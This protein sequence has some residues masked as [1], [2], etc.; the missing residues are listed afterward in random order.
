MSTDELLT[1]HSRLNNAGTSVTSN[2]GP[3]PKPGLTIYESGAGT[4]DLR[5]EVLSRQLF[6]DRVAEAWEEEH[7]T[8]VPDS[9]MVRLLER[10]ELKPG[11]V[12]LD[13]GCGTGRLVPFI[14]GKIGPEGKLMAV[15][16]SANML[17]IARQKFNFHNLVFIQ[18]D[19]CELDVAELF[20][21]VICLCL[22]PHLPDKERGLR[23]FKKYL[24]PDGQLIIAH[25]ASRQEV[26]SYHAQLPEPI[27]YDQL[28]EKKQMINLLHRTGFKLL[29][30]EESDV[31]FLRASPA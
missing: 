21:R 19:V 8:S 27:C 26:N 16:V 1:S 22:F 12:V 6:F 3:S 10:L 9:K 7:R 25:T 29:E 14:L 5:K 20:D 28:P 30:L 13:A 17:K 23:A 24:K 31:Y 4:E 18:A 15:D 2:D 11:Q